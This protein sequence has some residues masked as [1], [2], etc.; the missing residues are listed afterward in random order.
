MPSSFLGRYGRL[1]FLCS[2]FV[3]AAA[4]EE[5]A[6]GGLA[7][8]DKVKEKILNGARTFYKEV[9]NITKI[10]PQ[11]PVGYLGNEKSEEAPPAYCSD[12][13]PVKGDP[14]LVLKEA[15][16]V[17][18]VVNC[19]G[20]DAMTIWLIT[21]SPGTR[22]SF[23]W[24]DKTYEETLKFPALAAKHFTYTVKRVHADCSRL[25]HS[26]A[27]MTF[28]ARR[29]VTS[30]NN[31]PKGTNMFRAENG[32]TGDVFSYT[33]EF[34]GGKTLQVDMLRKKDYEASADED[35]AGLVTLV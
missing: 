5:E 15:S 6:E 8:P 23:V 30:M 16:C 31:K 19:K 13:W 12:F 4:S 10:P 1:A 11:E 35:R 17:G 28:L 27:N 24:D 18:G 3:L 29:V 26:T 7:I 34:E 14:D 21:H 33:L 9:A 20:S 32:L 22:V 2:P 25:V